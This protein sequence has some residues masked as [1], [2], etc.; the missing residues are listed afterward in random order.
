[1]ATMR[2]EKKGEERKVVERRKGGDAE[3]REESFGGLE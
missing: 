1:M 3:G 2:E